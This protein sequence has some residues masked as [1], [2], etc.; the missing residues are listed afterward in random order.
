MN[1]CCK[2]TYKEVYENM[3]AFLEKEKEKLDIEFLIITLKNVL[4]FIAE[5]EEIKITLSPSP[6]SK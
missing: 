1:D 5:N 3:I 4:L 6:L 2:K